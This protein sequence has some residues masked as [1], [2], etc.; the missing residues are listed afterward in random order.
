VP[1]LIEKVG[2][3]YEVNRPF[4]GTIVPIDFYRKDK[5]VSSIMVEV[6][7]RLYMDEGTGEKSTS[8][9]DCLKRIGVIMAGIRQLGTCQG[10]LN[11]ELR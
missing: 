10:D 8:F 1:E 3:T 11:D 2:W 9:E 5:R 4:S 7:R 6:N